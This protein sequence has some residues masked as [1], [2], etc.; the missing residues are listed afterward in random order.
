MDSFIKET[1]SK[2]EAEGLRLG[3]SIDPLYRKLIS[4]SYDCMSDCFLLPDSIEVCEKC[5]D[6]CQLKVRAAQEEIQ[7][8]IINIHNMFQQCTETC[9]LH[10]ARHETEA[11]KG[12]I[13]ECTLA[14][15]S[16]FKEA[17]TAAE[18]IVNKY[19]N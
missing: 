7:E 19:M 13:N 12:C 15:F 9:G 10:S 4:K 5:S 8:K 17:T 14:A 16:K 6:E 2:L 1:S 11:L 18:S 3:N